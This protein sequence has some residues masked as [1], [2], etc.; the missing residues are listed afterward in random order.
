MKIF[1]Y[2][3]TMINEFGKLI[4][5]IRRKLLKR[6]GRKSSINIYERKMSLN[7]EVERSKKKK[8]L[9]PGKINVGKLTTK[10]IRNNHWRVEK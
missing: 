2:A 8:N 1:T 9:L 4:S 10:K 7:F 5:R 6:K 3:P